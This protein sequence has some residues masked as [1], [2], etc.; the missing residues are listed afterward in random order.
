MLAGGFS[1]VSDAANDASVQGAKKVVEE[2]LS[3]KLKGPLEVE[4]VSA[5][6]QVVAG[7]NYKLKLKVKDASQD[8]KYYQAQ[9][10]E[11]LPC[12]GGE[13]E[14]KELGEVSAEEAGVDS[15]KEQQVAETNPEVEGAAAYAVEQLSQQS[16]SLFPFTLK[17]IVTAS[18]KKSSENS[19]EVTYHLKL[20]LQQGSMPEQTFEVEVAHSSNA[21]HLRSSQMQQAS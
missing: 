15:H 16:N 1:S 13:M 10:W 21:Y 20:N 5:E 18:T 17:K 7:T 3:K 11:K 19:G 12:Y 8:T 4:V 6:S 14:L 9:V 2:A